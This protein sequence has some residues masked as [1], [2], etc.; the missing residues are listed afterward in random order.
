MHTL[1]VPSCLTSSLLVSPSTHSASAALY[2]DHRRLRASNSLIRG[3]ICG[4]SVLPEFALSSQTALRFLIT[5]SLFFSLFL[6]CFFPY[7]FPSP[8]PLQ[9]YFFL[10]LF[11]TRTH[12]HADTYTRARSFPRSL[13]FSTCLPARVN[14]RSYFSVPSPFLPLCSSSL[15]ALLPHTTSAKQQIPRPSNYPGVGSFARPFLDLNVRAPTS[16]MAPRTSTTA[17][18]IAAVGRRLGNRWSRRPMWNSFARTRSAS[19][20][21]RT[22]APPANDDGRET[23]R[24][25]SRCEI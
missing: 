12:I 15:V 24:K 25:A 10:S 18:A 6:S 1:P 3:R 14:R 17:A 7:R 4:A 19:G 21:N 8:I 2:L 23:D 11:S 16:F 22:E 13:R 5:S 9:I 20:S